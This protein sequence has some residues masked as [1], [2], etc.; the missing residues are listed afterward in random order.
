MPTVQRDPIL[1]LGNAKHQEK[2]KLARGRPDIRP[3]PYVP[4]PE[5]VVK[6][7]RARLSAWREGQ[8][9]LAVETQLRRQPGLSGQ[10]QG[11][12]EVLASRAADSLIPEVSY[13]ITS[14]LKIKTLP[15][16][17]RADS[18]YVDGLVCRMKLAHKCMRTELELPR[19]LLLACPLE[20][21]RRSFSSSLDAL[22]QQEDEHMG[23]IV[24]EMCA[25]PPPDER[26]PP[27]TPSHPPLARPSALFPPPPP[28]PPPL[29]PPTPS[30]SLPRRAKLQIDLLLVG[31]SVCFTAKEKLLKKGIALAVGVKPS[32]LQRVARCCNT[33]VLLSPA[34]VLG[35]VPG[36]CGRW[37][38]ENVSV[39]EAD[40]PSKRVTLMYFERCAP[41]PARPSCCAAAGRP[42]S[43]SSRPCWRRRRT[44]P[45]T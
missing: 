19:I 16:G 8:L 36:T 15:G 39:A 5:G 26:P 14:I 34:Q 23:M 12:L 44:S 2:N 11:P 20:H 38:V 1:Q 6:E 45:P 40:G 17:S 21:E 28:S 10:W 32:V 3:P 4:E 9:R 35:T 13:S 29:H 31:G 37:R 30:R 18:H 25:A 22:R 41:E 33:P 24:N 42:S 7:H 27:P 43:S